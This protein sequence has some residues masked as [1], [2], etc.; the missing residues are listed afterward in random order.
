MTYF[1]EIRKADEAL[2]AK[3]GKIEQELPRFVAT[4]EQE[5]LVP[6]ISVRVVKGPLQGLEGILLTVE[7]NSRIAVRIEQLGYATVDMHIGMVEI[8]S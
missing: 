7:G 6:G 3:R 8:N 1:K 4:I 2:A 5:L